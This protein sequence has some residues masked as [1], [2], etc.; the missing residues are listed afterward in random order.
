MNSWPGPDEHMQ[1]M[2]YSKIPTRHDFILKAELLSPSAVAQMID[3]SMQGFVVHRGAEPLYLNRAM[4]EM[5]GMEYADSL[6][7]TPILHWI[8]ENDRPF[9][10]K[11]VVSRLEG[12]KS[13]D[14]IQFRLR[15]VNGAE[16]WVNC[17]AT[18]V[19][20]IDG[21]AILATCI[22]IT[23]LKHTERAHERSNALFER[24]FQAT[25]DMM[26]L[27]YLRSGLFLDVNDNFFPCRR[28]RP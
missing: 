19:D 4:A 6:M 15:P 28:T 20:W 7:T 18:L 5:V 23:L 27:S 1:K 22:D 17:R 26:S 12:K 3:M 14:E 2:Q 13:Q 16:L 10:A 8:H 25:P 11:N 21:P 24:V 9:V